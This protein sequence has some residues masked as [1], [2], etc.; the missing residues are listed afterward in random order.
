M[1]TSTLK[2]LE[3][4][5]LSSNHPVHNED[6]ESKKN[7]GCNFRIGHRTYRFAICSAH[8]HFR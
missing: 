7:E 1:V 6:R 2:S 5:I 4:K 8:Y 3:A